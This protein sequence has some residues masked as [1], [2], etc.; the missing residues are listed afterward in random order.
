MSPGGPSE[1]LNLISKLQSVQCRILVA[2]GDGTA[3]WILAEVS[4]RNFTHVPEVCIIPTGTGNDLSRVLNWG[5]E[6]P[7]YLNTFEICERIQSATAVNL[8]R[9][10][11]DIEMS[12]SRR[13]P[14]KWL[15]HRKM[16][17]YN[18]ISVGVDAQVTFDFH[19]ARESA[20][21]VLSSR[22]LNKVKQ[23]HFHIRN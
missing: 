2:G 11:V 8:D 9:W 15:P 18:Y 19:K 1:A 16:F 21:Y 12:L 10:L 23:R 22:L 17:M 20:F 6:P 14:M 13:L 5:S 4:K 3:G 7:A